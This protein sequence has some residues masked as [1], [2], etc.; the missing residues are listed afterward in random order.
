M[1]CL[2]ATQSV[3]PKR[4]KRP[5]EKPA[6][7]LVQAQPSHFCEQTPKPEHEQIRARHHH[8]SLTNSTTI[9]DANNT[10][11]SFPAMWKANS[12]VPVSII[13]K[14]SVTHYS[15]HRLDFGFVHRM[16]ATS[17]FLQNLHQ[18]SWTAASDKWCTNRV[19]STSAAS[20]LRG[21]EVSPFCT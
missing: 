21:F 2:C 4:K 9:Q 7:Q 12:F 1:C 20:L 19:L 10:T 5:L 18:D 14:S 11:Q 13:S 6:L 16:R 8:S 3:C 15:D 17:A